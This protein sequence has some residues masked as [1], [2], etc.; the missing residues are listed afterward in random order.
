MYKKW[1]FEL[2]FSKILLIT[3]LLLFQDTPEDCPGKRYNDD[4][5]YGRLTMESVHQEI[6]G[7][8]TDTLVL[9]SGTKSFDKDMINYVKKIGLEDA[10]IF[11]F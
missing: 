1:N 6:A 4:V 11:K 3:L 5:Q 8:T 2:Y 10:N 9:I 7:N